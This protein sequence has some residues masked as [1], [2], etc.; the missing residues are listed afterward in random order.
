MSVEQKIQELLSRSKGQQLDEVAGSG[1]QTQPSQGSSQKATFTKISD[2]GTKPTVAVGKD[3]SVAGKGSGEGDKTQPKQGSSN[4]NPEI[5]DLGSAEDKKPAVNTGKDGSVAGKGSGQGDK[6]QPKQGNSVIKQPTQVEEVEISS[7]LNAIFGEELSEEFK[8]KATSIFEAAVIARVNAELE[9]VTAKLEEQAAEQ[10]VEYKETLVEKVDTYLNYIVEQWMEENQLAVESGL[11]TEI[12]ED[13]ISSLQK[14]FK[15]HYIEVPAEKYDV[16]EELESQA[17]DLK[18]KLDESVNAQ[19]ELAKELNQI[20]CAQI[21][22]EQTKDLA[23]TEAEK[24]KKLVEGVEFDSEDL[25]REKV[26]VIKEN[27][28]PKTPKQS[29]EQVLTEQVGTTPAKFETNG[30]MNKYVQALSR[31]AKSR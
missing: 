29:P 3:G 5:D 13:F 15:E 31:S 28:F 11:R 8:T 27:Y 25:Y 9:T 1:D 24:L 30:Q 18:T 6:T 2:A 7:Q 26:A 23:D 16:M 20:K 22:E 12:A 17:Q 10:L 14:V 19:I 4:P 21:L